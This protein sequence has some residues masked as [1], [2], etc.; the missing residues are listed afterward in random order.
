[1]S[2]E[3]AE[4]DIE[5]RKV[6]FGEGE[7]NELEVPVVRRENGSA[8]PRYMIAEVP[9]HD[10]IDA[11]GAPQYYYGTEMDYA[12][13]MD[14][15]AEV[16]NAIGAGIVELGVVSQVPEPM[17]PDVGVRLNLQADNGREMVVLGRISSTLPQGSNN[18]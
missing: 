11:I 4:K 14:T 10:F 16:A 2:I 13:R 18:T 12:R 17:H 9:I 1:M 7:E 3:N 5:I 6:S 8:K 15:A